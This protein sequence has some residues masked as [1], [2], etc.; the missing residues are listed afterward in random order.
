ML[1]ANIEIGLKHAL[2]IRYHEDPKL[3][4]AF[5]VVLTNLLSRSSET[6]AEQN[7]ADLLNKLVT[8]MH[9]PDFALTIALCDTCS[10]SEMDEVAFVLLNIFESRGRMTGF[11]HALIERE[12]KQCGTL[13]A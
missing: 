10:A 8:L 6:G 2:S 5:M 7:T 12:V 3:R 13:Y 11:L 1:S 9:E 4:T